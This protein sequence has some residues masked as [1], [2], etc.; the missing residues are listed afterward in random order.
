M[1][2]GVNDIF[3]K[4]SVLKKDIPDLS[5]KQKAIIKNIIETKLINNPIEFTK[6]LQYNLKGYRSLRVGNYRVIF[7]IYNNKIII[8][9][10]KHRSVSYKN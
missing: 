1:K 4:E 6:P 3:Y 10:I 2:F 7:K 5:S 9:A 8:S